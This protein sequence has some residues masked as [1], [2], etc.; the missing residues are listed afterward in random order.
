[1]NKKRE[2]TEE[3]AR[4]CEHLRS[5]FLLLKSERGF[6]QEDA[7]AAMGISQGA[8][9]HYL[10]GRNALNLKAGLAFARFLGVEVGQFSPRLAEQALPPRPS[11]KDLYLQEP[12]ARSYRPSVPV[13]GVA[14]L[15][16]DG[17]WTEGEYPVG[18]GDGRV[19][20][21]TSD[22]NA[23]AVAVRGES[24]APR[25]RHGEF[26]IVEPNHPVVQG[27]EVLVVTRDGRSMVKVLKYRR[28]GRVYLESINADHQ[29]ISLDEAAEVAKIHYVSGIAKA[30]MH[31]PDVDGFLAS[32]PA[33]P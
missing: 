10:N 31:V 6:T 32:L 26:V 4:E 27:E 17:Y 33:T 11:L 1:M 16:A 29:D 22:P 19:R 5:L 2:L 8:V 7:A 12:Q 13:V 14:Q 24:M 20:W 30:A 18:H 21:P 23:Y 25:I 15:G 9:N 3:E 28:G